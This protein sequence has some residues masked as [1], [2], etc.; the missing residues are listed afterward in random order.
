MRDGSDAQSLGCAGVLLARGPVGGLLIGWSALACAIA[1]KDGRYTAWALL[2]A[3][4]G[5]AAIGLAV[6]SLPDPAT[7]GLTAPAGLADPT[8]TPTLGRRWWLLVAA[9]LALGPVLRHPRYYA[10]GP[11][12]TASDALAVGAGLIAAAAI[13][14]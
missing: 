9:G 3:G 5:V 13:V 7:G 12:A 4:V 6:A 2:L 8:A 11:A 14:R 1:A 10:S